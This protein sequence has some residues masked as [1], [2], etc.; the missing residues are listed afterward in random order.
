MQEARLLL[1]MQ[2]G[3][4][5]REDTLRQASPH[6]RPQA[7]LQ[8]FPSLNPSRDQLTGSLGAAACGDQPLETGVRA[9]QG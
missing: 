1:E 2:G 5:R 9:E 3:T 8:S 7:S 6:L 4:E